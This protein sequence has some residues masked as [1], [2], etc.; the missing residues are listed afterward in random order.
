MGCRGL[1]I[2][3]SNEQTARLTAA[4]HDAD[5]L[6]IIRAIEEEWDEPHLQETDK[7][8][9][10]MHRC[11]S[12]GSLNVQGG[13]YP[14]NRCVLGGRQLYYGGD[15]VISFVPAHEVVDVAE[16]LKHVTESLFRERFFALAAYEGPKDEDDFEYT[17]AYFEEVREFYA[18]AATEQRAVA[19]SVDQ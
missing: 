2:A 4:K 1:H 12:D 7:S 11:L 18:R 5:A 17:W 19:F 14:L 15:H 10:A 3:L 6:E 8:W 16:T 13:E 9:D